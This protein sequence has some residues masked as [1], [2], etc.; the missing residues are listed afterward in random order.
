MKSARL[1]SHVFCLALLCASFAVDLSARKSKN[2]SGQPRASIDQAPF[3]AHVSKTEAKFVF[4]VAP[5]SEWRWRL[6]ETE[7]NAQEYRL[8]VAVENA[9]AKYSFGFYL[10]KRSGAQPQA[11]SLPELIRAGQTSVF[12]RT[13]AGMNSIIRDA[14]IKARLDRDALVITIRGKENVGR[15]FSG[16][17]AEVTFDVKVPDEAPT[18]KTVPVTYQD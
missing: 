8:S 1:I 17:P 13:P 2:L 10:W 11:G 7:D 18:T 5:R 9:G 16:R 4:P 3:T 15:L 12:E 6:P 14:G